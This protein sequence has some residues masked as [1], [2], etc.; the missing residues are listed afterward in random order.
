MSSLISLNGKSEKSGL[1]GLHYKTRINIRDPV[2]ANNNLEDA[3]TNKV[4]SQ[5]S[6]AQKNDGHHLHSHVGPH[7][8]FHVGHHNVIPTLCEGSETLEIRKYHQFTNLRTY[9]LTGVGARDACA[10]KNENTPALNSPT[11]Q[12]NTVSSVC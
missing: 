1:G 5:K 6:S 4:W 3:Q 9:E 2:A 8:H 11:V 10:S 7:V 12:S